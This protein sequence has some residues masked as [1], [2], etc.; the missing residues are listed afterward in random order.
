MR[1]GNGSQQQGVGLDNG[2]GVEYDYGAGHGGGEAGGGAAVA[3]SGAA[4]PTMVTG[5]SVVGEG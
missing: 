5:L 2:S 3:R 4:G 1:E